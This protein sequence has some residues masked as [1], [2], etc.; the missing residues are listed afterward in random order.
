MSEL[1]HAAGAGASAMADA[2][3]VSYEPGVG[4]TPASLS[5]ADGEETGETDIAVEPAAEAPGEEAAADASEGEPQEAAAEET[6]PA[7]PLHPHVE[8]LVAKHPGLKQAMEADPGLQAS[9]GAAAQSV[10][11]L[12]EFR[13][14]FPSLD[15]ARKAAGHAAALTSFDALYFNE[16]PEASKQLLLHLYENQFLRDPDTGD[17]VTDDKGQRI[18]SGAYERLTGAYRD[19]LFGHMVEQAAAE[20][21]HELNGAVEILRARLGGSSKSKGSKPDSKPSGKPVASHN[22]AADSSEEKPAE[23]ELPAEVQARLR[24]LEEIERQQT[25]HDQ[26]NWH[27]YYHS[28]G[29]AVEQAVRADIEQALGQAA[30]PAYMRGK[31]V[32]DIL[33]DLNRQAGDD[34]SYQN[35]VQSLLRA[36]GRSE[37]ARQ[38]IVAAARSHARN[39]IAPVAQRHLNQAVQDLRQEQDERTAKVREQQK[40]V[41]VKSS[42]AAPPPVRRSDG[43]RIRAAEQK[44][45]RRLSDREILDL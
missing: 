16:S 29:Q 13:E 11:E 39:R 9:L 45:G 8:A 35:R 44:L 42:G 27:D 31:L 3:G 23:P 34:A 10:A 36:S 33:Q 20:G 32:D 1:E 17:F 41:E 21:D 6:T 24:R 40:R 25:E 28:V 43:E 2:A 5:P 37:S 18:S 12:T 15:D 4:E 38:R 14:V 22:A 7:E 26:R 19:I 30:L